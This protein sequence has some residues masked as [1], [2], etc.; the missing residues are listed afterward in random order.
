MEE[1]QQSNSFTSLAPCATLSKMVRILDKM[2]EKGDAYHVSSD[3]TPECQT[4]ALEHDS[5]SPDPQ[6]QANVPLADETV[7]TSINKLDM[8]SSLMFNE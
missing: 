8:L 6:S 4:T 2:K 5:L 3:P 1:N 7:T